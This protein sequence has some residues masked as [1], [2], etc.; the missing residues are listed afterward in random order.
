M[1]ITIKPV[2]VPDILPWRELYRQEMNCQIVHDSLHA[3]EGWT[4]PYLIELDGDAAGYGSVVEVH[5]P[6]REQFSNSL[7]R[8]SSDRGSSRRLRR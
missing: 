8:K 3:R 7:S 6:E 5:G 2:R 4:E 1:G